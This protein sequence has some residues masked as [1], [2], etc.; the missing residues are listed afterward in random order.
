MALSYS[1]VAIRGKAVAP[2]FAELLSR[3]NTVSRGIVNFQEDIKASTI[4]TEEGFSVTMQAYSSGAPTASGTLGLTDREVTPTKVMFYDTFDP[5]TLRTS[6][7]NQTMEAGAFNLESG[8]FMDLLMNNLANKLA[9][10]A[11]NK[12]WNGATSATKTAVAALTPGTGQGSVG[13]AEQTYVAA[14]PAGLF[15]GVATFMIYNNGALGTRVKVAG[16][17]L[18]G[19]NIKTEMDKVYAA[20]PSAALNNDVAPVIYA[21]YSVKQFIN[22]YNSN[23]TTRD[24]FQV[25]G[26]ATPDEQYT[27]NGLKVEFVP[28]PENCVIAANPENILWL[29]DLQSDIAELRID[30]IANNREDMFYKVIM[31]EIAHVIRQSTNVLYLG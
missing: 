25:A 6:R 19:S 3:N 4:I 7:F 26:L 31:T 8:E 30:K 28:L 16:T 15:D 10:E 11:E 2:V 24:I 14:A 12:F 27:Y 5:E 20:I 17:T 1:P 29:T 21:P 22:I 9:K 23:Q 18:S 13:A